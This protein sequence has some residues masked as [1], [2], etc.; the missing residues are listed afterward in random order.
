MR[1]KKLG[2]STVIRKYKQKIVCGG[3]W[4]GGGGGVK[5]TLRGPCFLYT[6]FESISTHPRKL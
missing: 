1:L 2:F 4:L 5:A 6:I 3:W